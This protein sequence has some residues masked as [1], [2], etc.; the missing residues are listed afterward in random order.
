MPCSPLSK[1][2]INWNYYFIILLL[3]N[4]TVKTERGLGTT[5]HSRGI[6]FL[7]HHVKL[8]FSEFCNWHPFHITGLTPPAEE[9]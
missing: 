9:L 5:E 7:F 3:P 4:L 6:W 2:T 1:F 8:A